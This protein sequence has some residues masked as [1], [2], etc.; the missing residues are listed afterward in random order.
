MRQPS[1]AILDCRMA[2]GENLQSPM[3]FGAFELGL[4]SG[5]LRKHGVKVKLRGQSFQIL[6]M[7]LERPGQV[8]TREELQ[9]RLWG[10]DTFVDFDRGLNKAVNRLRDALGDSAE[11]PRFI[12]T[13]PKR[14]Y[15]FIGAIEVAQNGRPAAETLTSGETPRALET[16]ELPAVASKGPAWQRWLLVATILV[17]AVAVFFLLFGRG[18]L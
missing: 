6:A 7:L 2:A 15:R 12:E 18:A 11:S 17:T 1:N 10:G 14:G 16:P 4:H 8:I 3:R 13:L 5:E 9:T